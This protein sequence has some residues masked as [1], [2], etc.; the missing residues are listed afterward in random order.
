MEH[1]TDLIIT[2]PFCFAS[3]TAG[4]MGD[5]EGEEQKELPSHIMNMNSPVLTPSQALESFVV[6]SGFHVELVAAEPLVVDPVAAVFAPDGS[7]W[8]VEMQSFMPDVDGNNELQPISRIVHLT[9][10]NRDLIMDE[11]TVFMDGLVLPR[12]IALTHDGLLLIAPPN[13]LYC[14]DTDGDGKCDDVQTLAGGFGGLDSVEHAGNG[15]MFG[16]DNNFHNSQ[17]GSSFAFDGETLTSIPVPAHGQWG[18]AQD[19]Y[20]RQY[21]SPNSYP[22]LIDDMPKQYARQRGQSRVIDGLYRGITTDK[23]VWPVHPTP[24]INRGYQKGRLNDEYKLTRYDAACGPAVYRDTLYGE[25]FEGNVF[26][27]ETVGNL[28]SRFSIEDD[29]NGSLRAVPAYKQ[30]EFL[31]STD[32]RFRP[33]NLINGPDGA[34]YIV[35]MYRGIAQH[36]MFVT[37]FLRKQIKARGLESPLGLGRIWRVVPDR[38]LRN[39]TPDLTSM[40]AEELVAALTDGN[41]T[42]RDMAQRLLTESNDASVIPLLEDIAKNASLDRDRIKALWTL[43]G[44][45]FLKKD[46]VIAAMNDAHPMVRTNAIRLAEPWMNDNDVF[47]KV[48]LLSND[49][50][51][52]VH[53]QVALSAGQRQGP[54]AIFFLLDQLGQRESAKYRSAAVASIM[55]RE[56]EALDL[57]SLNATLTEDTVLNRDTLTSIANQMITEKSERTNNLLM[58]FATKQSVQHPWQSQVVVD[59]FLSK[60]K[61]AQL[62]LSRKPSNYQALFTSERSELYDS[63]LQLNEL[64]WWKG[65]PGV[66]EFI[67]KRVN[68]S[69]ANLIT[70]GKKIYNVCK[71]CHQVDGMGLPPSYP[72]L[73]DSVFV[74]DDDGTFIKIMLHGLTGPISVNGQQFDDTMPPAPIR[75]DYDLAAVMTYVRQAWGNDSDA[76]TPADVKAMRENTKKRKSMWTAEELVR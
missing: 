9:D 73:V 12:G 26:V 69:V 8:V 25:E 62:R 44:M 23:R 38:T 66:Q 46:L 5:N 57:I 3:L 58:E 67:P 19:D 17:H 64:L 16:L 7:L 34:I 31:A 75:N 49:S 21:Y 74:L 40:N 4:Q 76:I 35:D 36:R 18:T 39:A 42:I 41:G 32:E 6:Q 48:K 47:D 53:R 14:R 30:E 29:G 28:V 27:C 20:G 13:L 56:H 51:F 52:Y 60:Q 72:S 10:N 65:R 55:G 33:V 71:T 11:A 70:R 45:G 68:Q 54:Q 24:G 37:S 63:V 59:A 43:Q 15:L 22:V 50:N 61:D 1:W 2:I